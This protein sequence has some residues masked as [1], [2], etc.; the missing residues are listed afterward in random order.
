MK[1][2][3]QKNPAFTE[4]ENYAKKLITDTNIDDTKNLRK[5]SNTINNNKTQRQ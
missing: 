1:I 4:D 2:K 3:S 5:N